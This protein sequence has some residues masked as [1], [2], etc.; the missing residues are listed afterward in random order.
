MCPQGH[1]LPARLLFLGTEGPNRARGVCI[2]RVL[3]SATPPCCAISP[4]GL[5][6]L[7]LGLNFFL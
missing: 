1:L 4:L 7:F 2:V 3:C 5:V 6:P